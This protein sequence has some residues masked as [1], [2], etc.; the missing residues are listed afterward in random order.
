MTNI[1]LKV[2]YDGTNFSG[3]QLQAGNIPTIQGALEAALNRIYRQP[4]RITAAGRTD[5]GVHALGQVVNY[6]APFYIPVDKIPRAINSLVPREIV[7]W[8]AEKR[9]ARF[10]A[11]FSARK[12]FYSY[13]LDR[14]PFPRVMKRRYT[15]HCPFS[16]DLGA[17]AEGASLLGGRHDFSA[18]RARGSSTGSPVKTLHR[19]LVIN[20]PDQ[21]LLR[22]TFEGE[23]FLYKMV[24][25]MVGSLIRVG[26]GRLRPVDLAEA[27]AGRQPG[28]V[29]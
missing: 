20:L 6:P 29:G 28:A 4:V 2:S 15:W 19:V 3:F 18:F 23:G 22:F 9:S 16:L 24:R 27:L 7:V 26:R 1:C 11:R 8:E 25:L 17:M 14:A 13:T 21:Q 10:H 5:A 12:K